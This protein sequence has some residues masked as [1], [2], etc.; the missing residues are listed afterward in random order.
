MRSTCGDLESHTK[1]YG[2]HSVDD[3]IP[4]R[5]L[6]H[7]CVMVEDTLSSLFLSFFYKQYFQVCLGIVLD[8]GNK[9]IRWGMFCDKTLVREINGDMKDSL[10]REGFE[11]EICLKI[12]QIK[13][14]T[15]EPNSWQ[16]EWT[17]RSEF[18]SC[19]GDIFGR[20]L[21]LFVIDTEGKEE[22]KETCFVLGTEDTMI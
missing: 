4:L 9:K 1:G 19:L 14:A 10:E 7:R 13:Q 17:W 3:R 15:H 2:L 22:D 16:W 8:S 20:T 12:T 11:I 5:G 21:H 6:D 18:Q